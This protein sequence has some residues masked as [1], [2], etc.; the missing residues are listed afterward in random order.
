MIKFIVLFFCLLPLAVHAE[1]SHA[2]GLER[3]SISALSEQLMVGDIVFV[4]ISIG[5]FPKIAEDTGSWTNHVGIITHR[6]DNEWVVSEST[7]PFSR[8]TKLSRFIARSEDNR[9]AVKRLNTSLSKPEQAQLLAAAE[10]R[11]GIFYDSGFDL[12]SK[13]Q[14]C[15]RYVHEVVEEATGIK[16]GETTTFRA[17]FKQNPQADLDFWRM[18]YFGSI[19]WERETITPASVLHSPQLH[20]VFDGYADKDSV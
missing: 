20:G 6:E 1:N 2:D 7:F 10:K 14:F 17:L 8:G 9:V 12:R 11:Y 3:V 16:V 18:W 5:P 4:R 19:P 15:S 13:W